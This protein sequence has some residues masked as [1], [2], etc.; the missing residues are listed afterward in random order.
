[1]SVRWRIMLLAALLVGGVVVG[2]RGQRANERAKMLVAQWEVTEQQEAPLYKEVTLHFGREVTLAEWQQA[3]TQQTGLGFD[4]DID[5]DFVGPFGPFGPDTFDDLLKGKTRFQLDLPPMP[6]HE[7]L[8]TLAL[9]HDIHWSQ[10]SD[11]VIVWRR[12]PF[13]SR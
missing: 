11:G 7:V 5:P 3:F 2:Y 6:A 8:R 9:F 10:R 12:N 13:R 1:M 4:A